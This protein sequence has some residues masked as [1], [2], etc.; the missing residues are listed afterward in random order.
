MTVRDSARVLAHI[1]MNSFSTNGSAM[2]EIR[3]WMGVAVQLANAILDAPPRVRMTEVSYS[4][5]ADWEDERLRDA[6][7]RLML[8]TVGC[9]RSMHEPDEQ[10]VDAKVA[11]WVLD[12]VGESREICVHIT[13]GD[14]VEVLNLAMLIALARLARV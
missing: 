11:G 3:D 5:N 2:Y 1:V 8:V 14:R 13:Q 10:G 9:R 4:E 7:N 12:N 6:L